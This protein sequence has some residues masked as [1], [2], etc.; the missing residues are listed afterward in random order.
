MNVSFSFV[1]RKHQSRVHRFYVF[2][3]YAAQHPLFYSYPRSVTP[4]SISPERQSSQFS[5]SSTNSNTQRRLSFCVTSF[6]TY[7]IPLCT[8]IQ[9]KNCLLLV[10]ITDRIK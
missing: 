8:Y 3:A 10:I 7:S 6:D 2:I 5:N 1:W 9:I 4:H